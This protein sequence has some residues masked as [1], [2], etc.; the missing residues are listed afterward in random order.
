MTEIVELIEY[1][2]GTGLLLEIEYDGDTLWMSIGQI[3]ALLETTKQNVSKHIKNIFDEG[4]LDIS[5]CVNE[6]LTVVEN[7][8]KYTVQYYNLDVVISVGYRVRSATATKFR[9]W[10]TAVIKERIEGNYSSFAQE[11]ALRLLARVQISDSTDNLVEIATNQH[12]VKDEDKFLAAGDEGLYHMSRE[13]VEE[14][15]K[16]PVGKLYDYIGST[17]LGM[18]VY[19]LTQ[20]SEALKTDAKKGHAHS[21]EEAEEI[22]KDIAER[23][24]AMSHKTHGNHPEDLPVAENLELT[25]QKRETLDIVNEQLPQVIVTQAELDL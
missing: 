9:Q 21:Q 7:S 1:K 17:E 22:H 4:E 14:H 11:E 15:R 23:T 5:T 13:E 25:K 2:D 3:A 8:R 16:I 18:H 12:K 20:T 6:K 10:A 19:R 24:R